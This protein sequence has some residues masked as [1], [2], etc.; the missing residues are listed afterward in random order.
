VCGRANC[1][2]RVP[3]YPPA[4]GHALPDWSIVRNPTCTETGERQ[5]VC[6]RTG[7]THKDVYNPP[8]LGHTWS[9]TITTEATCETEGSIKRNCNR[10]NC[11]VSEILQILEKLENCNPTSVFDTEK[12][13]GKYGIKFAVNPV[14]DNAEISVILPASTA[15]AGSATV[16]TEISVVI[17]DMTGNVVFRRGRIFSTLTDDDAIVWDLRNQTGRFVANGTYLVIAEAKDRNGNIYRYSARLG[18]KR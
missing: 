1:N 13:N 17:Y 7:C 14:S 15:S 10:A 4:L 6:D 5:R 3:D 8:A 16:A 9:A 11:G 2:H 12:S 18:V